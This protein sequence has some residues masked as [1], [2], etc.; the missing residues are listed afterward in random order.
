MLTAAV[1]LVKEVKLL[2]E[3]FTEKEFGVSVDVKGDRP[4][5]SDNFAV[6]DIFEVV[7]TK[8]FPFMDR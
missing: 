6:K 8:R 7:Q 1:L 2:L 4:P 5:T 3:E